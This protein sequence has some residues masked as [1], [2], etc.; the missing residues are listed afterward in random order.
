M[1]QKFALTMFSLTLACAAFAQSAHADALA[2]SRSKVKIAPL[3]R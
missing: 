1:M 2:D 3:C